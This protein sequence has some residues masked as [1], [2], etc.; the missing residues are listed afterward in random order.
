VLELT[1]LLVPDS[2]FLDCVASCCSVLACIRTP[3]SCI[4]AIRYSAA[5][6]GTKVPRKSRDSLLTVNVLNLTAHMIDYLTIHSID[7]PTPVSHDAMMARWMQYRSIIGFHSFSV[8]LLTML[9][10]YCEYTTYTYHTL[11]SLAC[12]ILAGIN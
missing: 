11:Q 10:R 8:S 12:T 6:A 2:H 3:Y 7:D 1:A 4:Q 9:V 5:I